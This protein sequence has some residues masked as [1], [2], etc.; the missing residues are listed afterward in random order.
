MAKLIKFAQMDYK[1]LNIGDISF[2]KEIIG[3]N[4]VLSDNQSILNYSH[5]ETED[6]SYP[7]EVVLKPVNSEEISKILKYCNSKNI[8]VTPCGARTGLSGGSLPV[9]GG[10]ALSVERLNSII[11]IDERNLQ[12]TVQPAVINQ[13]FRDAVELKE[14]FYPPDPA[15]K[16]SCS[17][18]GNLAENAGGPKAVKYGVTKDYVLNLEVVLPTGEIIWT[19]AN[20]LKNATGYDLT[21]LM[22]GSEGTLGVITTIVFRLIPLPKKDITLFVPF[23]SVEKACEAV[24]AVFRAGIIP[25]ALEFIERDAI[26]WTLKYTDVKL[27]INDNVKVHLLVEVDGNDMDI[28]YKDC[29]RIFEV[30]V[31]FECGE[32]LLA[33]S[34]SQKKKIWKLRRSVAEAVKSNSVYKE[35]DTVVPRAELAKLLKGV[36]VIGNDYGFKSVCYG[37]AGD[38]NLH[39]NIIKGEMSDEDWNT[40]LTLGIREIFELTKSLGGTLSGEHGIGLVQKD[41]MDIVFSE[42]ALELQKGIK[43]L[44]D[45]KGIL[46]PGK[47]LK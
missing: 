6:L 2:F 12:A 24:S 15:S 5:D 10:V 30:M 36:K 4:Y 8:P 43:N 3:A 38:G 46:N 25:S 44:F 32:I 39:I 7:P 41:Y 34:E 26:D 35:V 42:K 28:L 47:I 45:P 20:V 14:L 13:V 19:G 17:L 1:Q 16:G 31:G 40:K 9:F 37:H 18:G 29:E 21:A 27:Q 11:E 23:S 33:D 22:I